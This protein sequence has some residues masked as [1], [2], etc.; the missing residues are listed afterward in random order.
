M[1]SL[2]AVL[3]I[4]LALRSSVHSGTLVKADRHPFSPGKQTWPT[5]SSPRETLSRI[6]GE[7]PN[8]CSSGFRI[9][10]SHNID[11]QLTKAGPQQRTDTVRI[12][13]KLAEAATVSSAMLSRVTAAIPLCDDPL[14][15]WGMIVFVHC[16]WSLLTSTRTGCHK[17][18]NCLFVRVLNWVAVLHQVLCSQPYG[19]KT[20]IWGPFYGFKSKTPIHNES[21]AREHW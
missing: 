5:P 1:P 16:S 12:C 13:R 11:N 14:W 2:A 18:L 4:K 15:E 9:N 3:S 6:Y 7:I 21:D 8:H 20:I 17:W 10:M 19:K